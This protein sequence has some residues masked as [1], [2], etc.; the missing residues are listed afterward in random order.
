MESTV[1]D[2]PVLDEF[3]REEFIFQQDK[4]LV[5]ILIVVDSSPSMKHH[6]KNLGNSLSDLLSIISNYDWQIAVTSAYHGYSESD[7][8]P[9][10]ISA[11]TGHY[12]TLMALESGAGLLEEKILTPY[13]A[14]YEEIFLRTLS[15]NENCKKPPYCQG[16]LEQ[17]LRSL[18]SAI[19][20]K[21]L[22]DPPFFRPDADF[23]S[24]IIT[25]EEE[26]FDRRID[27]WAGA[28][29]STEVI[30][31][32]NDHFAGLKKKFVGFNI[33]VMDEDCRRQE[34][35]SGWIASI[36]DSIAE[37][38]Y[39]TGGENVS[40]CHSDYS[41]AL[42]GISRHIKE[43][44]EASVVLRKRPIP[45]TLV[46]ELNGQENRDWQLYGQNLVFGYLPPDW[47]QVSITYKSQP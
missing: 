39:Q 44:F 36:G 14:N 15:D 8:W 32:F 41:L 35:E 31:S 1:S 11:N 45:E 33:L 17:P 40:I 42:R 46:V 30:E 12:G 19:R 7:E 5:D 34:Q 4:A 6:L 37:L 18:K 16:S 21:N 38:A 22:Y 29:T 27:N 20:R 43:F 25:N 28:T 47:T 3:E 24:L 9:L 13:M 26:R 2:K 23:V 10:N